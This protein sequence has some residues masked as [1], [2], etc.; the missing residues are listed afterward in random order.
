MLHMIQHLDKLAAMHSDY[1]AHGMLPA[2]H[3]P[4]RGISL[5]LGAGINNVDADDDDGG[6]VEEENVGGHV[7]LACTCGKS[8]YLSERPS[9]ISSSMQLSAGPQQPC[10][11]HR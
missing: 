5:I 11:S 7:S 6:P 8:V 1:V 10:K 9:L 2:G 4:G 3:T